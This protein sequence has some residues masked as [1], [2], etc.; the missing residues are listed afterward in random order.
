MDSFTEQPF[1][2]RSGGIVEVCLVKSLLE[3]FKQSNTINM[4]RIHSGLIT[5]ALG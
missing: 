5:I 2:Q 4:I 3:W 1:L